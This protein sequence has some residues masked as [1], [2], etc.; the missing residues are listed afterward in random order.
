MKLTLTSTQVVAP[1]NKVKLMVRLTTVITAR[2]TQA[3]GFIFQSILVS[4]A[5]THTNSPHI[6]ALKKLKA[7]TATEP[8]KYG[9]I[10]SDCRVYTADKSAMIPARTT[11]T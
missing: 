9:R 11:K 6:K 10:P 3:I 4:Q 5:Y 8:I 1:N 7:L 2:N